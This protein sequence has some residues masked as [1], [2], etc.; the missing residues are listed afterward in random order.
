MVNS[1]N[2]HPPFPPEKLSLFRRIGRTGMRV[3]RPFALPLLHRLQMRFQSAV[4]QSSVSANVN[5]MLSA[6]SSFSERLNAMTQQQSEIAE[7][8]ETL[9]NLSKS[10]IQDAQDAHELRDLM[11]RLQIGV[12]ALRM[13]QHELTVKMADLDLLRQEQT[14][15]ARKM[16]EHL[17]TVRYAMD[18]QHAQTSDLLTGVA[19]AQT[20]AQTSAVQLLTR[21]D[22]LIRRTSLSLGDDVLLHT[23]DGF[24]LVPSEDRTLL[25]AVWES[26]GRLEPGTV[27]VLTSLLR[28]GDQVVDVGAHIGLTVLPAARKV[29]PKGQIIALEPGSRAGS[30]LSQSLALNFV[31]DRVSLHRCAAGDRAGKALLHLSPILGES[32]LLDLPGSEASEEIDVRTVD[33]LI[34]IGR[35]VRLV[36]IDAEGY[37][38]LVW[39]GMQR[40]RADNPELVVLIEFGPAHLQRNGT[41][42]ADWLNEFVGSGFT[43]YEIEEMTGTIKPI[44]PISALADVVSLNLLMLRRPPSTY[45][46]LRFE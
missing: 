19:V 26:G 13:D 43:P 25:A 10:Q 3:L 44:R 23:P 2:S 22:T 30:L 24:L 20:Q 27:D 7:I 12:D 18:A 21:V 34:D 11:N 4:D 33:S 31:S 45:P 6:Q 1:E 35:S 32:S 15:L 37:E 39:R 5:T 28:E 38:L 17:T 8:S 29:G 41:S 9:R 36:K 42:I 14:R 40:V 16:D 46:E